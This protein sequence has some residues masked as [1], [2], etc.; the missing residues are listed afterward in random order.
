MRRILTLGLAAILATGAAAAVTTPAFA[1]E[2]EFGACPADV[3]GTYPELK[4]A[5]LRVPLDYANPLGAQV[6]VLLS[7]RASTNPEKRRG[8]LLVNPGG[9]TGAGVLHAGKLT[10]AEASGYTRLPKDVLDAYDV[11]GMDARGVGHSEQPSCVGD[12]YWRN[13]QPDPDLPQQRD[14]SWNRWQAYSKACGGKNGDRLRHFGTRNVV[15]DMDRMLTQLGER[16]LSFLGSGYGAY[17]GTAFGQQYPNRLDRVVFDSSIHPDTKQMWYEL[18]L[19][20]VRLGEGRQREHLSWIAKYDNVFHLG[21]TFDAVNAAWQKMLGDFRARPHG[22]DKNVGAAELLDAYVSTQSHGAYWEPLAKAMADYVLRGDERAVLAWATPTGGPDVERYIASLMT[23][24][25]LDT[26]WP[27]DRARIER[28]FTKASKGTSWGWYNVTI[29][30]AC[31]NWPAGH[32]ARI[33]TTGAGLPPVLMFATDRSAV[34]PYSDSVAMH[35]RLR[36]SVLVTE[37]DSSTTTVT[38][39]PSTFANP[40]A[41]RIMKEYLVSGKLPNADVS[42]PPHAEPV[43]TA[44]APTAAPPAHLR[45]TN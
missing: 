3:A 45:L 9:T 26:D 35:Q 27:A 17:V 31:A 5:N 44:T 13:M 25:C 1:G 28:D 14:L 40:Q 11:I 12:D 16:K 42:V 8:V 43:P 24:A 30:S 10:K 38:G 37:R 34:T 6:N 32:E 23:V 20:Q 29:P 33:K 21:K 4:C 19:E 41:E 22:P 36:G 18:G 15:R 7:K 2:L 39:R